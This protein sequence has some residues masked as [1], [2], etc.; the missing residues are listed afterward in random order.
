MLLVAQIIKELS[1]F[2]KNYAN[3]LEKY[4][5]FRIIQKWKI[6][7]P[8]WHLNWPIFSHI[9]PFN[10]QILYILKKIVFGPNFVKLTC[11]FKVLIHITL[12]GGHLKNVVEKKLYIG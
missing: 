4:Y 2:Q 9:Q 11:L 7:L 8:C 12:A 6:I 1:I 10:Y 3:L 5:F